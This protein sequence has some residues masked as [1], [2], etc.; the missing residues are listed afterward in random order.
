MNVLH[1]EDNLKWFEEVV[2]PE[3]MKIP[4]M[5]IFHANNKSEAINCLASNSIDYA[6]L[7]LSVPLDDTTEITNI[8]HGLSV[9]W[10]IRNEYPGI[11]IMILTGESTEEAAEKFEE[12]NTFTTYWD[13]QE[14][15]LVK[16]R[17]KR[18]VSEVIEDLSSISSSLEM[19]DAIELDYDP[20]NLSLTH[21]EK[22]VIRLF[23]L[24]NKA[25][26]AK[27]NALNDGLS[28]AK[29]LNVILINH[30]SKSMFSA[31]VKIDDNKKAEIERVNFQEHV[32]KLSVGSFP[33]Y[34]NEFY[35]GCSKKKGVFFQFAQGFKK[36]YFDLYLEDDK[37]SLDIAK[38]VKNI[39]TNWI[40]VK[41]GKQ[42]TIGGVRRIFC[43]DEKF[44][45]YKIKEELS[46]LNIDI[47]AFE[48]KS[49][50][51]NFCMQHADLH[52]MNILISETNTP[53]IIDYGDIKSCPSTFDP[54]TLELS[55]Y[56]HPKMEG[57]VQHDMNL[58]EHWFDDKSLSHFSKNPETA[59]FLR[60][61]ARSNAFLQK[62]YVVGVYSY[63]IKQ[64]TYSDT[65]KDFARALIKAAI[66][67][68]N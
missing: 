56:F 66:R 17:N 29:V 58:A 27:I 19:L 33:T 10:H 1:L 53:L 39:F 65:N 34:I 25:T 26:A 2:K 57:L 11:P 61:W 23:C 20:K 40:N 4:A 35:A 63:I 22:R 36:D 9:A 14:R 31:L 68:F 50:N 49:L 15:S 43:S 64:F 8:Q 28:S 7:D 32:T 16:L 62:D 5:N 41:N 6:L 38:S 55:P 18:R 47:D 46:S 45:K 12:E 30:S 42:V 37:Q 54:I 24:K 21:S 13:G 44:N 3:L 52:G 48:S 60:E 51:S 59:V 67:E